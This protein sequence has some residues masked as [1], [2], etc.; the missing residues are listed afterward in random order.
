MPN[1]S[2]TSLT[3]LGTCD[4]RLQQLFKVVVE[5][6]DC[7]IIC[8]HRGKLEQDKAFAEGASHVKWPNSKH[9]TYPSIAVDVMPYPIDWNDKERVTKFY[10]FVKKKADELGIKIRWGA[11]W[12]M[13]GNYW[14]RENWEVDGP[15]YELVE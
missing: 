15:H 3:K 9:N 14:E 10:E 4:S 12:D 2:A 1:F 5:E 6:V 11:D 7:T 13:D 8:G